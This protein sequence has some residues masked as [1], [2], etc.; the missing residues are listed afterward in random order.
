M[1]AEIVRE[2]LFLA[3]RDELPYHIAVEVENWDE[4]PKTGFT[5]V[6]AVIYAA[7]DSHKAMIIGKGG[8]TIKDVGSQ[9][10]LEIEELVGAKVH[11]A[12]HVKVKSGWIEDVRFLREMGLG[13]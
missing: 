13:E 1:T 2:K 5:R 9:A 10:R 12:L 6:D 8:R 11:L 7:K 3:L 4:D